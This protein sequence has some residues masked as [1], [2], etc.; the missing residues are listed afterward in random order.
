M[1]FPSKVTSY[2]DSIIA[3]LP[4]VLD[5]LEQED[6][7]PQYLYAKVKKNKIPDIKEFLDVLD[8]LYA[9]KKIELKEEV[10]HYVG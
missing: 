10:L 7:T 3:K 5:L 9:L 4:V 1:R 6:M 2:K 8:C